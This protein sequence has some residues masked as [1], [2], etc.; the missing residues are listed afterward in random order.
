MPKNEANKDVRK[1][2][3][4][5]ATPKDNAVEV[6]AVGERGPG[7][8]NHKYMLTWVEEP[9]LRKAAEVHYGGYTLTVVDDTQPGGTHRYNGIEFQQGG[10]QESGVNGV[11]NE[12]L[13]AV[14]RDRLEG[15]Q[16]G[17]FACLENQI[18]LDHVIA[19]MAILKYRTLERKKRGVEG[20]TKK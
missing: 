11:T 18:A 12:A 1:I 20:Q 15:F 8:A 13:L 19:A 16:A 4:H 14:V 5:K 7:N 9:H 2:N 6:W 10:I 17:D 3:T